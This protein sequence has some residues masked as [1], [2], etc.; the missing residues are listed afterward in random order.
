MKIT[1]K[2]LAKRVRR[3]SQLREAFKREL[4]LLP[5][6]PVLRREGSAYGDKISRVIIA[7]NE[8]A[9]T[10]GVALERMRAEANEVQPGSQRN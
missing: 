8:A 5:D 3:L 10:L 6:F 1:A 9:L 2:D 4:E 7:L